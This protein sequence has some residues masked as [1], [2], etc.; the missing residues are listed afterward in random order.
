MST[1]AANSPIQR[2]SF[3]VLWCI[4]DINAD[5]NADIFYDATALKTT[6]ATSYVCSDWRSLLLSS[7]SI[8]AHVMDLDHPLCR[9]VEGSREMVRRSGAALMCIKT[10]SLHLYRSGAKQILNIIDTNWD[11]I[12]KLE[13]TLY[14]DFVDQWTSLYRPALHLESLKIVFN[15]ESS[16][17]DNLLPSLFSGNAPMLRNLLVIFV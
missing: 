12:Q 6:L 15:Q 3:D 17:F 16:K 7:T 1:Y 4:F 14:A 8:W 9:K 5:I 10:H 2:L 13:V 11:R